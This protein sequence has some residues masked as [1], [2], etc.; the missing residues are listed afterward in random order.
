M[1]T[2]WA[3]SCWSRSPAGSARRCANRT[4]WA[5]WAA[6][7]FAVLI[8]PLRHLEDVHKVVTKVDTA[9]SQ[10]MN[11]DGGRWLRSRGSASGCRCIPTTARRLMNCWPP[12]IARC[13]SS[14]A[15]AQGQFRRRRDKRWRGPPAR[16]PRDARPPSFRRISCPVI[17]PC[18]P[19][20]RRA[21]AGQVPRGAGGTG[22]WSAAALLAGC[23]TAP[24]APSRP[25]LTELLSRPAI[26]SVRLD[27]QPRQPDA[28][29]L[30]V[31]CPDRP[32]PRRDRLAVQGAAGDRHPATARRGPTDNVGTSEFNQR[33]S[34]RRAGAV[35]REFA[36]RGLRAH[37]SSPSATVRLPIADNKTE[38]GGPRTAG[39]W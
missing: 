24:P 32:G 25:T 31:R 36:A 27:A 11:L 6:T 4:W 35:A 10:P 2:R 28:V 21:T 1:A 14:S 37:R 8:D 3:T 22:H 20:V 17:R 38:A 34:M 26:E 13:T 16:P 12:P 23:Q 15:R 7:S 19:A 29:R 5:G 30:R 9:V 39:W 18:E 33:L